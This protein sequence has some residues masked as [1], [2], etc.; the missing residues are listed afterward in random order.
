MLKLTITVLPNKKGFSFSNGNG[1]RIRKSAILTFTWAKKKLGK[2][3]NN[4]ASRLKEKVSILVKYEDGG[5]NEVSS[6][7]PAIL[8]YALAC[9]LEDYIPKQTLIQIYKKYEL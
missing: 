5:L 3:S 9:F 1:S 7:N 6:K 4:L 2:L 8:L